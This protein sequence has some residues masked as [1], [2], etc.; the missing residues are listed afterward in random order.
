[1]MLTL[2]TLGCAE[3]WMQ[4]GTEYADL[5]KLRLDPEWYE[6]LGIDMTS[7]D[8]QADTA[9]EGGSWPCWTC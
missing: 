8:K 3:R 6:G 9:N 2:G 7:G 5:S 4:S 1:M